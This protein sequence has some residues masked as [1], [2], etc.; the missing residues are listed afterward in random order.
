MHGVEPAAGLADVLH[1]E[2]RWVVT[3][4]KPF[5]VIEGV[6]YLRIRHRAGVKPDI[7]HIFHTCEGTALGAALVGFGQLVNEWA[8]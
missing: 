8:V 2:V 6:V 5:L 7:E 3:R 1:N 4:V